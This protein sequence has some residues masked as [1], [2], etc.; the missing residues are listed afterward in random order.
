MGEVTSW[1]Q[2][3]LLPLQ[4]KLFSLTENCDRHI[5]GH[6]LW[7]SFQNCNCNIFSRI[8]LIFLT[9]NCDW[10]IAG[11][12]LWPIF[13]NYDRNIYS[14]ISLIFLTENCDQHTVVGHNLW[15]IFEN[16]DRNIFS[17]FF[18]HMLHSLWPKSGLE[19]RSEYF[20]DWISS[21]KITRIS[22]TENIC[23]KVSL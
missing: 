8:S 9:E 21:V 19:T 17:Q 18:W 23:Q 13:Q 15:S 2:G 5:V 10:H 14:Q 7:P 4:N 12:N 1:D 16:F 20:S 11:H 3:R 6:N 22:S